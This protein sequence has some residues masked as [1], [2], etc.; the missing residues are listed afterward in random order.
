MGT[1]WSGA[2]SKAIIC[3][4]RFWDPNLRLKIWYVPGDCRSFHQDCKTYM[5]VQIWKTLH[6]P[7]EK[8]WSQKIAISTR[9]E[10]TMESWN[11]AKTQC[12]S[13]WVDRSKEA[14]LLSL[15][16]AFAVFN[17]WMKFT[18][19]YCLTLRLISQPVTTECEQTLI[20]YLYNCDLLYL[21]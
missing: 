6:R 19:A 2:D 5:G 10:F 4:R 8:S 7:W 16:N 1:P 18:W 15:L 12:E 17:S 20:T 21:L 14:N 11:A 9:I 13:Y 3:Q